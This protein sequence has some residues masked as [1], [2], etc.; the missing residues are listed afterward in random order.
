M[1]RANGRVL[2][3]RGRDP[4]KDQSYFLFSLRQDQL[5]RALFP[6]GDQ[7]KTATRD[8]AMSGALYSYRKLIRLGIDSQVLVFDGLYH[9]FM[10]NPDFPEA[11]EG[12]KSA[13]A[14][15]ARMGMPFSFSKSMESIRRS[16]EDS[17]WLARKVPDCLRRQSTSVVLP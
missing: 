16:S 13:A 3:K 11:Q 4:R 17:C 15:F 8:A 5:A 12:Y 9:G 10:T 14:F 1:E 6:V 2:L 7:T